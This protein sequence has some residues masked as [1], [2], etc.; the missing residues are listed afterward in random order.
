MRIDK[1]IVGCV[2]MFIQLIAS[3]TAIGDSGLSISP[4]DAVSAGSSMQV[5]PQMQPGGEVIHDSHIQHAPHYSTGAVEQGFSPYPPMGPSGNSALLGF[6][7]CDPHSCPQVW[8][9]YEAQRQADL[10][11]RCSPRG[12]CGGCGQGCGSCGTQSCGSP[13]KNSGCG[14]VKN[15]YRL[16]SAPRG[17]SDCASSP[18]PCGCD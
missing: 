18:A 13:C 5:A 4:S 6:M 15:R 11:R 17:C 1:V 10:R 8:A 16:G 3:T 7:Q 9:G 14:V 2:A 12:H